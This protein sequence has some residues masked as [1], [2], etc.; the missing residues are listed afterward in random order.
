VYWYSVVPLHGIVFSRMLRGL[1][2][3]S[4][5]GGSSG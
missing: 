5:E 3:A 2:R 1:V 4:E